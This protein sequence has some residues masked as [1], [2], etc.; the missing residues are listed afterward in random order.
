M[1][2]CRICNSAIEP[3]LDFGQMPLANGFLSPAEFADECFFN[4]T[5]AWCQRCTLVQL[6]EQPPRER[7]FNAGYPF[8]TGSS[9]RMRGHF[10]A[11]A[12]EVIAALPH[13]DPLVVEIGSNDG[14]LL[15][16]V[17]RAG[18]RHL[19]I[20]PSAGVAAAATAAGV[21]TIS[22]FF[23]AALAREIVSAHGRA[24]AIIAANALSHV[25]GLHDVAEGIDILLA[26]RGICVI[27]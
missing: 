27:E 16:N 12:G 8:F 10:A 9:A 15:Q 18:I 6:A 11:L 26:P 24:D 4:L 1:S 5:A 3:F 13:G 25:S 19:G 21:T 7:M 23:D 22:R 20:E 2:R 14:T 17:A